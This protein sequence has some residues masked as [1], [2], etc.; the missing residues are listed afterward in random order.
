MPER[1]KQAGD[2][3]ETGLDT[4]MVSQFHWA[5]QNCLIKKK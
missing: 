4:H 1:D 5:L 3:S 2:Q